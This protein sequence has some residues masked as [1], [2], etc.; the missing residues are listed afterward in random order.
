MVTFFTQII[1]SDLVEFT[2]L[3]A[4]L[5]YHGTSFITTTLSGSLNCT[6]YL[7]WEIICPKLIY[8]PKI[9]PSLW[10]S[11]KQTPPVQVLYSMSYYR[12][13]CTNPIAS[14]FTPESPFHI[15]V[16]LFSDNISI[17]VPISLKALFVFKYLV[18]L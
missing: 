8:F 11:A 16:L 3:Q 7:S 10:L 12:V 18:F 13:W 5:K 17:L 14:K 9:K 15:I 6:S 1:D 2:Y 4:M